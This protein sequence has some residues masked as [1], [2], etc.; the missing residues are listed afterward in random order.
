MAK[1]MTLGEA[2]AL[3]LAG[4][5]KEEEKD[6][7]HQGQ[8]ELNKFVRWCGRERPTGS[9]MPPELEAYAE[10]LS[11]LP[12]CAQRLEPVKDFL[13][14]AKK[15][16]L[17]TKNLSVHLKVRKGEQKH[18]QGLKGQAPEAITLT[19]EGRESLQKELNA[20]KSQRLRIAEELR[21]AMADKDFRENAPLDAAREQQGRVEARIRELQAILHSAV[22]THRKEV[23][24]LKA[25]V[26]N[27]VLLRD[28]TSGEVLRYILVNPREVDP[29]GGK[30]S[31]ASPVGKSLLNRAKGD[32]VEVV[33]PS[34]TIRYRIEEIA[35]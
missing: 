5:Q 3:F 29:R 4:L 31:I 7:Y 33:V 35:R 27:T 11:G 30:I 28:L 2:A 23:D 34:G 15:A 19:Q 20:L 32:E 8:Q 14:Y 25:N 17:T 6:L 13:A 1:S 16:G 12:D 21:K 26:G 22:L 18:I 24:Q 9:L 10:G